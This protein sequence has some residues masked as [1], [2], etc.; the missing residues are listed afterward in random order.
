[1]CARVCVCVCIMGTTRVVE[2]CRVLR[3]C[4]TFSFLVR[5]YTIYIYS[6]RCVT[7]K[8]YVFYFTRWTTN[9]PAAPP[10]RVGIYNN[11]TIYYIMGTVKTSLFLKKIKKTMNAVYKLPVLISSLYLII[12]SMRIRPPAIKHQRNNVTMCVCVL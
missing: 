12:Y 1:M 7:I 3:N 6:R 9:R 8:I 5:L 2:F 10:S 11:V 4:F